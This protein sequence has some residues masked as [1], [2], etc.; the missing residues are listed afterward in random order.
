MIATL[1]GSVFILFGFWGILTWY[2]DF[3]AVLRGFLPISMVFGGI[4][5]VSSGLSS[6]R[7]PRSNEK[8]KK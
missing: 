6:L 1:I 4:V 3:L 2:H 5:A 7:K 8:T